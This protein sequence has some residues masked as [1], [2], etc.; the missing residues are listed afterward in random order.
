MICVEIQ[1]P[2]EELVRRV[3]GRRVCDDCGAN[4]DA[5]EHKAGAFPEL[6][7]NTERCR[8]LGPKWVARS[9]DSETVV[10]ERL[11]VYWR[12]TRPMIVFY[13]A[14]PTFRRSTA[15]DAGAG[16]GSAGLGGGVGARHAGGELRR[17]W[18]RSCGSRTGVS[19]VCRSAAEIEKLARV[20][21]LVA[22][23]LKE[24]AAT[25]H[26]GVTT[27]QL[28]ELAEQRL[29]EAGAE[30][31]FKGYHGYPATICASVNEQVV[32]G[33]PIGAAR[34]SKATCLDRHGR[35]ARRVLRDSAV[36]V[37]VGRVA[38]E[39]ERLLRVTKLRWIGRWRRSKRARGCRTSAPRSRHTSRRTG[40][41]WSASS[42]AT[43]SE[44]SSTRS[45]RFRITARPG[46][47]RGWR[48]AWRSP[49]SRW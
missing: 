19:I 4:A 41:R 33:I 15:A 10:R 37:P 5:F 44:P 21:A 35:E 36:T 6:C 9:D 11:K 25:V 42:S 16:A 38:P 46:A 24:L 27:E 40:F 3:R 23:V 1:V 45:R 13:S 14:R 18:R 39:A 8:A 34:W 7:Q 48:R 28:D 12:E 20:N 49:S 29:R 31:A 22:R 47:G 2:D 43:E 17:W 30:P 32:H 26:P